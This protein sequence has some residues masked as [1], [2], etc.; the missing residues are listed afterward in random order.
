MSA[1]V[2]LVTG[3]ARRLGRAIALDLAA[4]GYDVA[5]HFNSSRD[6]AEITASEVVKLGRKATLVEADLADEMQVETIVPNATKVLGPLTA[7][8]N[9]ASIFRDDR[10]DNATRASWDMHIETNL[11]APLVLAQA[12]AKQLPA[13][14]DGA[15]VNML[16]QAVWKLTPQF[17]SYTVSKSALWTLTRTLAQALGAAHPGQRH[18]AGADAE[19]RKAIGGELRQAGRGDAFEA[20]AGARRHRRGGALFVGGE[21]RDRSDDR[22][23]QWST[24]GLGDRRPVRVKGQVK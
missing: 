8:V 24:F 3:A 22:C 20:R 4:A 13:G 2:V 6:D 10:I 12:F 17:L 9:N 15:I 19:G 16:D 14:R 21:G 18:R 23:R 7:L 11:R 1:G 5:V